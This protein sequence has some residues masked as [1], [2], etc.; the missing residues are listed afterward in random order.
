MSAT[1]VPFS[2]LQLKD[3]VCV[4][5]AGAN[6]FVR[7]LVTGLGPDKELT[8]NSVINFGTDAGFTFIVLTSED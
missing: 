7:G 3:D 1:C 8:L 2:D 5:H 4:I 6:P